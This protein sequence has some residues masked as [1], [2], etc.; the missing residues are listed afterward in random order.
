M[1]ETGSPERTEP[2]ETSSE[3]RETSSESDIPGSVKS[4]D[5]DPCHD[6]A[7]SQPTAR[8]SGL[9][10]LDAENL[11]DWEKDTLK[12]RLL[13]ESED[14]M[15]AF[16][17]L[18][19]ITSRSLTQRQV[20]PDD[21]MECLTALGGLEPSLKV[22][23]TPFDNRWEEME[24]AG[25]I[26]QCINIIRDYLSFFNYRTIEHI[27]EG[28][29]T[30]KDRS[31]LK[32]YKEKLAEYCRRRVFECPPKVFGL[33]SKSDHFAVVKLDGKL[34]QYTLEQIQRF[35]SKLSN[36]I[37]IPQYALQLI[38]VE[39]GCMLL[40]FQIPSVMKELV[41]PL[42]ADQEKYLQTEGV[43]WLKCG[44]YQFPC[45]GVHFV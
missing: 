40:T 15:F 22:K 18:V 17:K 13:E 41:F 34:E 20:T 9:P 36:I 44:A 30:D 28:L 2:R 39:R 19:T 21:L 6:S 24:K 3:P 37:S 26:R 10:F 27:I 31:E 29:G 8:M 42:S 35:Q 38:S 12:G 32:R 43:L 1:E 14:M 23:T 33:P 4:G 25:S 5:K 11:K 7:H 45:K 16:Q